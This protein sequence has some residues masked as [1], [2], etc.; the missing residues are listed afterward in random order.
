MAAPFPRDAV[1]GGTVLSNLAKEIYNHYGW[2]ARLSQEIGAD[3]V[4]NF[5]KLSQLALTHCLRFNALT[6][7]LGT[8]DM[9]ARVVAGH[10]S[11]EGVE[12]PSV[13]AM[14]TDFAA[15]R[16]AA[17]VLQ[18]FV[19]NSHPEVAT[20]SSVV[21]DSQG[22]GREEVITAAKPHPTVIEVAKLRAIF[23]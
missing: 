10:F 19:L 12:W 18:Q 22:A 11:K 21:T 3:T 9:L 4:V 15:I 17:N 20:Y 6:G 2:L 13:A 8:D 5:K 16:A 7:P 1:A 14:R 23:A